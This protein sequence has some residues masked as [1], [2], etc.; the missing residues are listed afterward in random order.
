MKAILIFILTTCSVYGTC[1]AKAPC[2]NPPADSSRQRLL[3]LTD[4]NSLRPQ[5]LEADDAQSLIRLMLYSNELEIE[6]IVV[7]SKMKKGLMQQTQLVHQIIDAYNK[8]QPNLIKHDPSYPPADKLQKLVKAGQANPIPVGDD[9]IVSF[10]AGKD[11]E[12]SDWI[13]KVVDRQ[14]ARPVWISVWGGAADLAQAL[15]KVKQTRS[16]DALNAF[17]KKIRVRAITD[18]D[19]T[20]KWILENFPGIWYLQDK[21]TFRG[22]FRG[23]DKT[24]IDSLWVVHHLHRPGNPLGSLYPNYYYGPRSVIRGIKEGDTPSYLGMIPNGLNISDRPGLG[25]WGGLFQEAGKS[26]YTDTTIEL[27]VK[28]QHGLYESVNRWR[29]DYQADFSARLTWCTASYAESNH[30]PEVVVNNDPS[31]APLALQAIP[32]RQIVLD[33]GKSADPD[34][35]SLFFHWEIYPGEAPAGVSLEGRNSKRLTIHIPPTASPGMIPVLLTVTDGGRP[36]LHSYR[37][38]LLEIK[39]F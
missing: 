1:V 13:I 23:G 33:A 8:V 9:P 18:Q 6:G 11:T 35:D 10:G 4:I 30:A 22:M 34:G 14:D 20:G 24:L 37:R 2:S 38:I 28:E 7:S 25:G 12:G 29:A 15:W 19:S 31:K 16:A 27:P 26:F 21:Y 39:A 17:V 3:V 5:Y 32:G 36:A